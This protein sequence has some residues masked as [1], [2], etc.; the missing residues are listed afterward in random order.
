MLSF[1]SLP[2]DVGMVP[3]SLFSVISSACSSV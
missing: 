3:L 1:E 2:I